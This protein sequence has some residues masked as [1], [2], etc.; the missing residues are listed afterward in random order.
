MRKI[1]NLKFLSYLCGIYLSSLF[2]AN[3]EFIKI[4]I[5]QSIRISEFIFVFLLIYFFFLIIYKKIKLFFNKYDIFFFSF[6]ILY[7]IS[8][9]S[10]KS[11]VIGFISYLYLFLIYFIFKHIFINKINLKSLCKFYLITSLLFSILVII[12]WFFLFF[13]KTNILYGQY[14]YPYFF[15]VEGRA[16]GFFETSTKFIFFNTIAIVLLLGFKTKK[17]Y[18]VINF[19]SSV[20]T[21]SKSLLIYPLL[22]VT[23][24]KNSFLNNLFYK[25]FSLLCIFILFFHT[26][27]FITKSDFSNEKL[28]KITI[29][30]K[31]QLKKDIN[32]IPTYYFFLNQESIKLISDN[33]SQDLGNFLLGSGYKSFELH[34]IK[35]SNMLGE[36][37][38]HS[39]YFETFIEIGFLG[40][41]ILIL[42]FYKLFKIIQNNI[43]RKKKLFLSFFIFIL[44]EGFFS[45][46]IT[47]KILWIFFS[48]VVSYDKN[49]LKI[50]KN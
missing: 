34:N 5:N 47:F 27:F 38:V 9:L 48:L 22:L 20:L 40:F 18:I 31:I 30:S 37:R 36:H 50:I 11:S 16:R 13:Q 17:I 14:D 15:L 33:F 7:F 1:F 23:I 28:K 43:N 32:L 46:L 24:Y 41:F 49:Q 35:I 29:I 2:F 4:N 10:Q 12:G 39:L 21:Y 6:P 26:F 25:F 8:F 19:I 42:I 45:S 3:Y 44:I